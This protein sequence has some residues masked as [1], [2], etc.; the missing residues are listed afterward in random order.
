MWI[1]ARM[2]MLALHVVTLIDILQRRS[3][4]SQVWHL[5]T[6]IVELNTLFY[7]TMTVLPV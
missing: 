6:V 5:Y 3:P 7:S 1:L 4:K 2:D